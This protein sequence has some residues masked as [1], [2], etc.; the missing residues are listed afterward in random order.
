MLSV[1]SPL[2][3]RE[4]SAA[5]LYGEYAK[6]YVANLLQLLAI[7]RV[8][9][10]AEGD[11]LTD[12]NGNEV[13]DLLG[14]YG[15]TL[16]GH[17]HPRLVDVL[18][19]AYAARVPTHAQASVR[20]GSARLAE[21][22]NQLLRRSF[23]ADATHL[24]HLASTGTEAVEAAIKHATLEYVERRKGWSTSVEKMM[25]ELADQ[26]PDDAMV[27]TLRDWKH[28]I[29]HETPVLL[30][31]RGSYH[32]KT[33]ASVSATWN[34][35]F[36][37][38][39]DRAPIC[40][41]FL[42][43]NDLE[44][45]ERTVASL[46]RVSP[47]QGMPSFSPIVGLIFEPLQSEGGVFLL[48]ETFIRWME[49]LRCEW[50]MPLIADEIQS[51]FFRTGTF[52]CCDHFSLQPDYVLLGKSLGGGLSKIS[53]V[54]IDRARYVDEFGILHSSTFAED[55]PSSLVALEAIEEIEALSTSVAKRAAHFEARMRLGVAAIRAE[56]GP[57]IS[58]I[59]GKGFLLGIDFDLAGENAEIPLFLKTATDAGLGA[60]LFMSYFLAQHSIRVGVTVSNPRVIRVEPSIYISDERIDRFLGALRE[61]SKLV[62]DGKLLSMT[63]HLWRDLLDERALD[64]RS[65]PLVRPPLSQSRGL[66]RISFITH[67]IDLQNVGNMDATLRALSEAERSRFMAT[68]GDVAAPVI[69]HEQV[70]ESAG[71]DRIL[72]E[73]YGIMRITEFFEQSLRQKNLKGLEAVRAA[74]SLAESRNSTLAGLGQYTSIVSSNGLLVKDYGPSVT[75]GNSLT[76]GFAF[77][78]LR[79]ALND[80]GRDLSECRVGVV[81][82]AGNIC[83]VLTQ[84]IGD[85]AASLTLI[86]RDGCEPARR[87]ISA[88]D[89]V[90]ANSAINPSRVETS[91]NLAQLIDCDAIVLGT[92]TTDSLITPDV[93]KAGAVIVD[94]SV[95][96][97]VDPSVFQRR[98]DVKAYHGAL[99]HLPNGQSLTTEWM[100]LPKGQIYACLAETI[101]LGLSRRTGHYSLGALRKEQVLEILD[102]AGEMGIRLGKLVPLKTR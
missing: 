40:T 80:S 37:V 99:A 8:Y 94:I 87:M 50:G 88:M 33:A 39:F 43:A 71:G 102:L 69:Y 79:K 97:N 72:L 29:D 78:T 62:S 74:M 25:V 52:L 53:A 6:P 47:I 32:G 68:F 70:V 38:M 20:E 60:Y 67:F 26:R 9:A 83:N 11:V 56:T 93:L 57:F 63:A 46:T 36:R 98:P 95:P 92:N 81:G 31:V 5:T 23:G 55:E 84:V 41:A 91:A 90:L 28:T 85:H 44:Q 24:V 45:C 3:D 14:G 15:S 59:R 96:S 89:R 58:E 61:L 86:H 16:L 66:P 12:M 82:A 64:V 1:Q 4:K 42:D 73:L 54:C 75:T 21:R 100:P 101:T 35:A 51:G 22:I 76:A 34:P 10:K 30:A 2:V 65:K 27:A 7:D 19:A 18:C 13:L 17:N 49:K 48:P 77:A